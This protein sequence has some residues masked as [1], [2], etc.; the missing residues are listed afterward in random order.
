MSKPQDEVPLT[1]TE[2]ARLLRVFAHQLEVSVREDT[3]GAPPKRTRRVSKKSDI[4]I[5]DN[6]R[7]EAKAGLRRMGILP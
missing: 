3:R 4:E 5:S 7:A 2:L 1:K 6:D